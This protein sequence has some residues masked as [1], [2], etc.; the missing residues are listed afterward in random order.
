MTL[1]TWSFSKKKNSTAQPSGSSRDYTVYM[2][3]N[4]SIESPVLIIG[5]GIDA[6]INYCQFVGNFY[7][8]DDVEMLSK[9]QVALQLPPVC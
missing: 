8:I 6:G 5:T 7:F 9:D 1:K 4:T 3:E 2:K